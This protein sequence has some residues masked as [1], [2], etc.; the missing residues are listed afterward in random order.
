MLAFTTLLLVLGTLNFVSN[1]VGNKLL[2]VG[3]RSLGGPPPT[4]F[5]RFSSKAP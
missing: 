2:F 4:D 3:N 1:T 5:I